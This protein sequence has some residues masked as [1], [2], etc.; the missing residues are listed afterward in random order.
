MRSWYGPD[1]AWLG[2]EKAFSGPCQV[3]IVP[4]YNPWKMSTRVL[5]HYIDS[6]RLRTYAEWETD[7]NIITVLSHRQYCFYRFPSLFSQLLHFPVDYWIFPARGV[8]STV[9]YELCNISRQ[10]RSAKAFL[11]SLPP[12]TGSQCRKMIVLWGVAFELHFTVEPTAAINTCETLSAC[13]PA[14]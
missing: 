3:L 13:T 9:I 5:H 12:T 11:E 2:P 10:G 4:R 7:W 6:E 1:E 14:L 8:R